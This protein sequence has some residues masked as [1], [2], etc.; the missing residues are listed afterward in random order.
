MSQ[1]RAPDGAEP[2]ETTEAAETELV[3]LRAEVAEL[4]DRAG[5]ERR[6]AARLLV[7]RRMLAAVLIA[8]VAVV[9]VT[10]VVGVWGA[11]T[12]LN[13]DRWVATVGPLPQEPDVNK[14]VSTYLTDQIFDQLDV[15]ARLTQ[16]LPPRATF[17]AGPVSGSVHDFMQKSVSQLL[18]TDQFEAIWRATNRLAHERI[19]A[20]L[21]KKN[22]NVQ[23]SG[24]TVTLNLLPMVNN[25]LNS[26]EQQLPSLFGKKL[27]LPT[28][29][30]G[31]IPPGLHDRIEKALGVQL[32]DDFGQIRLYNRHTLGQLQ[33][34][35]LVFKRALVG[36]LIAV[37]VLLALALWAAPDRRRTLLQLGVWLVVTVT[38]LTTVLRAVRRQLLG[39]VPEGV[40]R[41]G[42]QAA[43]WTVFT[44]LRDR[45][46]QLLWFGVGLAALMYLIGPGRLPRALRR[47]TV[48]GARASAQF[49]ARAS[50]RITKD[51]AA[52]PWLARHADVLRVG[53]ALVAVLIALLLSSWTALFVV[54]AL[55][56]AYE[57]ALT[58]LA[59]P[60]SS[61]PAGEAGPAGPAKTGASG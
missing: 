7:V 57:I 49:A 1:D 41:D 2:A 36:L 47:W 17:L 8:L 40:Y 13:T 24:D 20:L 34:S 53:G 3:R 28:L 37:P 39:Q 33:Q 10:S 43:L 48:Q 26:L 15:Q 59:R 12:T 14:A 25:M 30:S 42:L 18:A 9:G 54:G 46:D 38:V 44:T 4:R 19:V 23:V 56:A 21:E 31:E 52:R 27:D 45:G 35:V 58:L 55:L 61:P 22:K 32:P 60:G 51:K 6:R 5:G 29:K 50:A 16:A 11:R